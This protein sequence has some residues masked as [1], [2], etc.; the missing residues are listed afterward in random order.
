MF[1]A[2]EEDREREREKGREYTQEQKLSVPLLTRCAEIQ[3]T[4]E[5]SPKSW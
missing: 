2:L 4:S 3:E 1:P 5:L